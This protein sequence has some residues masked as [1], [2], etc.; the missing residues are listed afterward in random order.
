MNRFVQGSEKGV[1]EDPT[2]ALSMIWNTWKITRLTRKCAWSIDAWIFAE[3]RFRGTCVTAPLPHGQSVT[4]SS[5]MVNC[6]N[7]QENQAELDFKT[8]VIVICINFVRNFFL[9]D[10][11]LCGGRDTN[12]V[13]VNTRRRTG[14]CGAYQERRFI[15]CT[16]TESTA[17]IAR[18]SADLSRE[19]SDQK[20]VTTH[21]H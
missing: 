16:P 11:R 12:A 5:R 9:L 18:Q 13:Q 7:K 19:E 1:L 10:R 14:V 15:L 2:N 17:G 6:F 4:T 8:I 21:K 20:P 3:R